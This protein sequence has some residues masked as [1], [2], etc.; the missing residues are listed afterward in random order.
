MRRMLR[1]KVPIAQIAR[2][3]GVSRQTI[4]N[5]KKAEE[6]GVPPR[7]K[8]RRKS[9]LDPFRGYL[10]S[11][12]ERFDVPA[13]VLFREIVAKGYTGGI[14]ILREQVARIKA[15]HVQRVV[16]RFETEPGRQAQV[17]FAHC[18]TIRHQGRTV[19]LSLIVVVLGYSRTIWARFL[20]TQRQEALM[21]SLEE[22]FRAFGGVPRE[23]LFDNLKQV[24]ATPRT[25][26]QELVLQPSFLSFA[27]HW[28]FQ[29]LACPV[30]WPRAK[31][32][33]ERSIQYLKKSFLEGREFA[34]LDDLNAQLRA[35]LAE[36]ANRRIHGTT[37]VRP[38]DRWE[39][40]HRAMLPLGAIPAFPSTTVE[41]RLA[42]HDGR[43]SWKGVRYSVDPG[44]LG[45]RRG[46]PVQVHLGT[47][48][49][50]RIYHE[51]VLVGEHGI[52]PKGSPPVDDPRHAALRRILRQRPSLRRPHGKSP[53]F[54]Q[55]PPEAEGSFLP[56]APQ[57]QVPEL[58]AYEGRL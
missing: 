47:D 17:D 30:Y 52:R 31:G 29:T 35:W 55:V 7:G 46:V 20:V 13:V 56:P 43:I 54:D 19:R 1:E 10:E 14:T 41:D 12:L 9:K 44:I 26:D 5:W 42:D 34:T 45:G 50:L 11:R 3:L 27:E 8:P 22:A 36:V 33:V 28:G 58:S 53:R 2:R 38:V 40:E 21:E 16:D 49:V 37:R 32:K 25:Q 15:I 23:L 48:R 39:E 51:G 18:G 57:V 6:E 24:V 4:Y